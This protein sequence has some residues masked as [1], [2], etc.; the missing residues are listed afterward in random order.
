[1][2]GMGTGKVIYATIGCRSVRVHGTTAAIGGDHSSQ[3][4][5]MTGSIRG[6]EAEIVPGSG[7]QGGISDRVYR[8]GKGYMTVLSK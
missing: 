5:R 1:M 7:H 4:A 8:N 2:R 6:P 3:V